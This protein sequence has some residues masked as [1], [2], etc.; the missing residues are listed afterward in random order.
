MSEQDQKFIGFITPPEKKTLTPD[1]IASFQA[2][3]GDPANHT[4]EGQIEFGALRTFV[5]EAAKANTMTPTEVARSIRLINVDDPLKADEIE[6]RYNERLTVITDLHGMD[7]RKEAMLA[8]VAEHPGEAVTLLGDV[9]GSPQLDQ[10]Q[11]LFYNSLNNHSKKY[12]AA[13]PEATDAEL[14]AVQGKNERDEDLT[15]GEGLKRVRRFERELEGKTSEEIEQELEGMSEHE[16]ANE[17]RK[18]AAYVHYGHYASNLSQ[19]AKEALVADV[20]SNAESLIKS[21]KEIKAKNVPVVM[22]QGNWEA[23]LPIDFVPGVKEAI[24]LPREERL[25]DAKNF[26]AEHGITYME[27][28]GALET[29]TMLQVFVPFDIS[30]ALGEKGALDGDL[31][32]QIEGLRAQVDSA[33]QKGKKVVMV[34]HAVPIYDIHN[35]HG[36]APAQNQE[37]KDATAGIQRIIVATK[38]DVI[39]YGHMHGNLKD[40]DGSDTQNNTFTLV[41]KE[42]GSVVLDRDTD[43]QEGQRS[44]VTYGRLGETYVLS[45]PTYSQ[46][47][48]RSQSIPQKR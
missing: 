29:K 42:D 47:R 14:L 18:Y 11:K 24:R 28:L 46:E 31:Q 35:L 44:T 8:S 33:R 43:S 15:I 30:V 32:A 12:L 23:A 3:Q 41:T 13:N 36:K 21:L 6:T 27:T 26:F 25:F 1:Q 39:M 7:A 4:P 45:V 2:L 17:V 19:E 22:I 37:N 10:L 40:T 20:E 16:I 5:R 38:P 48:A 34:S 9:L